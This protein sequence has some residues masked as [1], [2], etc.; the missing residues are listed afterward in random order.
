MC[1]DHTSN[2]GCRFKHKGASVITVLCCGV[3]HGIMSPIMRP[4]IVLLLALPFAASS[5]ATLTGHILIFVERAWVDYWSGFASL[6]K[7]IGHK[8]IKQQMEH[9]LENY[10]ICG[11]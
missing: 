2:R 11:N 5:A 4:L 7:K 9:L 8:V 3:R 1:R 10:A 6:S